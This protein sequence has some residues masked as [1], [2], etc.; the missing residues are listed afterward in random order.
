MIKIIKSKY[1]TGNYDFYLKSL[2]SLK[3]RVEHDRFSNNSI[4][5]LNDVKLKREKNALILFD[6]KSTEYIESITNLLTELRK[7]IKIQNEEIKKIS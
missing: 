1:Y 4:P 3:R 6:N 2:V 5:N 7:T